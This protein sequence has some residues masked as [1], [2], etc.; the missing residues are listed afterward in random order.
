MRRKTPIISNNCYH[1]YNRGNQ[2]DKIF[3]ERENYLFFLR[4]W[5]K[6]F[7][8]SVEVFCYCLM[9][10][11]YH[12]LLKPLDNEFSIKMKNFTISYSKAVNKRFDR[13][14][15]LFQGNFK[16]KLVCDNNIILHLTSVTSHLISRK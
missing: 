8:G 5:R 3:F 7:E 10:N 14:G 6:Y 11:H 9:S 2:K 12:F 16:A 1:I 4:N 13:V 15:H